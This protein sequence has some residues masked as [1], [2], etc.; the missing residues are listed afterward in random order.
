MRKVIALMLVMFVTSFAIGQTNP[1]VHKKSNYEASVPEVKTK[2]K[3]K[4]GAHST[5]LTWVSS[6]SSNVDGY[7]VYKGNASG[8]ENPTPLNSTVTQSGYI[9]VNVNPLQTVFYC[10]KAHSTSAVL[11][12][13]S[14][15][16]SPDLQVTTPGD[17]TPN[18][19]TGVSANAQ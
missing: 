4:A 9:D 16:S 3:A 13:L 7:Y 5:T 6:T 18:P 11:P 2:A 19:P 12:G 14:A 8:A 10:V 1:V 15:C 17:S